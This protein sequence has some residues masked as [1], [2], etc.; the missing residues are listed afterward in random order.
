MKYNRLRHSLSINSEKIQKLSHN[1][2][3]LNNQGNPD[4]KNK[5]LTIHN[6]IG[7]VIVPKPNVNTIH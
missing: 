2:K 4:L 3:Y 6:K 5:H 1:I 7:Y